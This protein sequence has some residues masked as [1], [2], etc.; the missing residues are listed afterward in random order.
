MNLMSD[1]AHSFILSE[2]P[3]KYVVINWERILSKNGVS[4]LLELLHDLM[5][6]SGVV[7]IGASEKD[8][9]KL[10]LRFEFFEHLAPRSALNV[11]VEFIKGLIPLLNSPS[12][13]RSEEHTSE[14]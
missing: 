7:V 14:L 12:I 3:F 1:Y 2:E 13:L 8:D 4:E 6:D 5:V 9:P 10:I 11:V